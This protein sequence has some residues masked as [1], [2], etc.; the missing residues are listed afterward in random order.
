LESNRKGVTLYYLLFGN[1]PFSGPTLSQLY[2]VICTQ[3]VSHIQISSPVTT[4][5]FCFSILIFLSL[6]LSLSLPL[7][8]FSYPRLVNP[9]LDDLFHRLLDKDQHTR[10]TMDAG[11]LLFSHSFSV[12]LS[13]SLI[14]SH[15]LFLS[16]THTF[17]LC[18]LFTFSLSRFSYP[19]TL[20]CASIHG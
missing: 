1:V 17:S 18:S 8:Q 3:E 7:F 9:L 10:I 4:L 16:H 11:V 20:Q 6:S 13:F 19:P 14:L 12:S 5:T 2:D 15:S